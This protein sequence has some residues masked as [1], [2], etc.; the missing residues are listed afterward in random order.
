MVPVDDGASPASIYRSGLERIQS[1]LA[2]TSCRITILDTH[3]G[4][5]PEDIGCCHTGC[6]SLWQVQCAIYLFSQ[7][8]RNIAEY[9]W[10]QLMS[11]ALTLSDHDPDQKARAQLRFTE[12]GTAESYT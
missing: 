4:G 7:T 6:L 5:H 12:T 9:Y 2:N 3:F 8:I 1:R 11:Y 10:P